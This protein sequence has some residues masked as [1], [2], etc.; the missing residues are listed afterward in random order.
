[1]DQH[2]NALA[3]LARTI[4]MQR[5]DELRA[6]L[7]DQRTF[8]ALGLD[9]AAV[10]EA[11]RLAAKERLSQ[12][13][14]YLS[15]PYQLGIPGMNPTLDALRSR[16]PMT[17]EEMQA[18]GIQAPW[19]RSPMAVGTQL[20][21]DLSPRATQQSVPAGA[22]NAIVPLDPPAARRPEVPTGDR[23]AGQK[24]ARVLGASGAG[25]AAALGALIE[26]LT[27]QE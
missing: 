24:L 11:R 6:E 19:H 27:P 4:Q 5:E 15:E 8:R 13:S 26:L 21:L 10:Q 22:A 3:A 7:L 12:V 17:P 18:A 9:Y 23:F 20:E 16:E 1:V 25:A 14:R 2:R